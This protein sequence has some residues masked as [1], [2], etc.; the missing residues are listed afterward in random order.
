MNLWKRALI[1]QKKKE[2]KIIEKQH[3]KALKAKNKI[4]I[5]LASIA[6]KEQA[7]KTR[8]EQRK[9][10][11]QERALVI[12]Q[13]KEAK[14]IKKL[15]LEEWKAICKEMK[16]FNA[17]ILKAQAKLMAEQKQHETQKRAQ[18]R[19]KNNEAKIIAKQ[20]RTEA[21]HVIRELKELNAKLVQEKFVHQQRERKERIIQLESEKNNYE[22]I[23]QKNYS[24]NLAQQKAVDILCPQFWSFALQRLNRLS[25]ED[26]QKH[27]SRTLSD[28]VYTWLLCQYSQMDDLSDVER[29]QLHACKVFSLHIE[30]GSNESW[31]CMYNRL[32]YYLQD[33]RSY[34]IRGARYFDLKIWM[35]SQWILGERIKPEYYEKLDALK[36]WTLAFC[37]TKSKY[38][39]I[40]LN[41]LLISLN[42]MKLSIQ[43][44]NGGKFN[45]SADGWNNGQIGLI[46][47][48]DN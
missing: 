45:N 18:I 47:H 6:L 17:I 32:K 3:R 23:K 43:R 1:K 25:E 12:Q 22:E 48:V 21:Q 34:E 20:Q 27:F 39:Q 37:E 35:K 36:F 10:E 5:F 26:L 30:L 44:S 19:Q 16:I 31:I 14:I 40:W 28:D 42:T 7:K 11:L 2:A 4:E 38:Y 33:Y 29:E 24:Q 8:A 41:E 9:L 13:N 46:S 15:H